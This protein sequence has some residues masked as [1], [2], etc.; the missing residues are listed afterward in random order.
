M[1]TDGGADFGVGMEGGIERIDGELIAF[2]WMAVIGGDGT[3]GEARSI[4]LPLPPAVRELIDAGH[5]LGDANDRVFGTRNSKQ[6]GGAFGLLTNGRIARASASRRASRA[7]RFPCR[8]ASG[9]ARASRRT[10]PPAVSAAGIPQSP[11]T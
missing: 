7:A 5:E 10:A 6:S 9:L 4:T 1:A 3:L 8:P 2:A 11:G